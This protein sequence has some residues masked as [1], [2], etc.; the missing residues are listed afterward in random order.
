MDD[1]EQVPLDIHL[2]SAPQGESIQTHDPADMG[3]RRL[4]NGHPQAV[5]G[6]AGSGVD[7]SFHL[8]GE[9]FLS[10]SGPAVK[11]GHLPDFRPLRMTQALSAELAGQASRLRPF[12]FGRHVTAN[13]RIEVL[14]RRRIYFSCIFLGRP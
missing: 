12:E 5:Q 2:F 8:F 7:L 10:F 9:G 1:A 3:K 4:G 14:K 13:H 11:I 6:T